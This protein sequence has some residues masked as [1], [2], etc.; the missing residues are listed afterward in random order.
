M[1]KKLT[2]SIDEDVIKF[3]HKFAKESGHSVSHI[4]EQ[5]LL[6]LKQHNNPQNLSEKTRRL[7]GIF[8]DFVIPEKKELRNYFHEKSAH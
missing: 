2:L 8:S 7:Y 5:F 6:S 1:Q 4:V 3:A